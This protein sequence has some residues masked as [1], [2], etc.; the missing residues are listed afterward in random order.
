LSTEAF[1]D[2]LRA[3]S[4][5]AGATA[6]FDQV[7]F[8]QLMLEALLVD[9]NIVRYRARKRDGAQSW[10]VAVPA[11]VPSEAVFRRLAQ[12]FAPADKLDSAWGVR[13]LALVH[14]ARGPILVYEDSGGALLLP[15]ADGTIALGRFLRIAV[16]AARALRLAHRRGVLHRDLKPSN[17]L[18]GTDG[19][20]R[21]LG[22]RDAFH[23]AADPCAESPDILYGTLAYM[24]PEQARRAEGQADER[25]DLYSLGVTLYELLT[26]R[27]LL[28]QPARSNGS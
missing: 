17:L 9:G 8:D 15:P 26:G 14:L 28:E 19:T 20:V 11:D 21:L 25:S 5:D 23:L 27:L 7:W 3:V 13:P 4:P 1:A 12:E 2:G 24:S 10:L 18:E 16:G 6:H 22:F